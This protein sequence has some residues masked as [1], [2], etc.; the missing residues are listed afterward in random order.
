MHGLIGTVKVVP[1]IVHLGMAVVAAGDAVVGPGGDDL[2]EFDLAVGPALIGKT[3]LEESAAAAAT[4][5]VRLVGR[6]FDDIFLAHRRFDDKAQ[7]IGN[8]V[9]ETLAH[10]LAGVLDG[11][12]DLAFLVPIGIDLEPSLADPLGVVLV[13]GSDLKFV[14][15]PEFLQS[16][17][18]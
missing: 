13:D 5:V 8:L 9:A 17:P 11:E 12:F 4:V 18:D 1:D 2:I 15:N 16:G 6:H 10:D 3:G 7:I 14:L